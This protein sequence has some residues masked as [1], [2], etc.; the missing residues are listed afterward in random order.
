MTDDNIN[1]IFK[2]IKNIPHINISILFSLK[3]NQLKFINDITDIIMNRKTLIIFHAPE[4]KLYNEYIQITE[5]IIKKLPINTKNFIITIQSFRKDSIIWIQ[6]LNNLKK[7][8]FGINLVRGN[9]HYID[10]LKYKIINDREYIDYNLIYIAKYLIQNNINIIFGTNDIKFQKKIENEL[11]KK[12]I[13]FVYK[14]DNDNSNILLFIP[15]IMN[16]ISYILN[17]I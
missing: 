9:K 6:T 17:Q 4:E 1:E 11:N 3:Y 10:D 13:Y 5:N 8:N 15:K 12:C 7:Y 16:D 2:K 14:N